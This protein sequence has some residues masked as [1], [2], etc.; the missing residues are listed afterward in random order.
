MVYSVRILL[1]RQLLY[2]TGYSQA[3]GTNACTKSKERRYHKLVSV[4]NLMFILLKALILDEIKVSL[5]NCAVT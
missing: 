5:F 2:L 3:P 1:T 4:R